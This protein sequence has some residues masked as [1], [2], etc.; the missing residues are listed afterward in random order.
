[1]GWTKVCGTARSGIWV[2]KGNARAGTTVCVCISMDMEQQPDHKPVTPS[3]MGSLVCGAGSHPLVA[4]VCKR[5][6]A[7][8]SELEPVLRFQPMYPL[9]SDNES[10]FGPPNQPKL[11][12]SISLGHSVEFQVRRA[13]SDLPSSITVDHGDLLVMDGSAQSEYAHRTVSGLQGPRVDLAY[14]WVTQ[15]AASCPLA[16]VVGCV[17]PSCV[18][19]RVGWGMG[20]IVGPLSGG[21]SSFCQSWCLSC[22]LALGFALGR[23]EG[24]GASSQ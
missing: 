18:R 9:H 6:C 22:W 3:G 7:N 17:L 16:G 12:V 11:I 14:R 15:H 8:R 1:M 10:L 5:E 21:R 23:E 13:S 24:E 2:L 19:V 4:L 20:K